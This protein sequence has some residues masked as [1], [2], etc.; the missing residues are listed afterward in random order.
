[1]TGI[2]LVKVISAERE[3]CGHRD[4]TRARPRLTANNTQ[5]LQIRDMLLRGTQVRKYLRLSYISMGNRGRDTPRSLQDVSHKSVR[6]CI[7]LKVMNRHYLSK[8]KQL[9]AVKDAYFLI[10]DTIVS[11]YIVLF[12]RK[13]LCFETIYVCQLECLLK[14]Y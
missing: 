5:W 8:D 4:K 13:M 9:C 6:L 11:N 3:I 7:I 1:M 14:Y 2:T 12:I 10:K